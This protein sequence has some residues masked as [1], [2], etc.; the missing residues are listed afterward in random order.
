MHVVRQAAERRPWRDID[1]I[2]LLDKPLGVSSNHALQTIKRLFRARKAGH[3]GSLDPLAS[4]MLPICFGEATK[5]SA[6]LLDADKLYRA[7][8]CLGIRTS[9]GDAEGEVIERGP[10]E[11]DECSLDR[12]LAQLRGKILQ[13]PPMHSALKHEGRRLYEL[14]REGREVPRAARPVTIHELLV[15]RHEGHELVLRVRCSKGT[16]I[17]TL[18]EDLA[19]AAGTVGH[20]AGLRRLQVGPF[21]E[22]AMYALPAFM[23]AVEQGDGALDALLL[24]TDSAVSRWPAVHLEA[25]EALRLC[26]GQDVA[27]AGPVPAGL[28]RLYGDGGRFL[29]IGEQVAGG[30]LV[31]RRLMANHG[32]SGARV[33]L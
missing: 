21:T 16:Y 31:P 14:A 5:M 30:R 17:R 19:A 13:T 26:R 33:G 11:V 9:T 1:G 18:V 3:T 15:E 22:G 29:G 6:Y 4:G 32:A 7:N 2:V 28:V 27:H 23:A 20:L 24:P 12:A 10:P 25:D 8:V